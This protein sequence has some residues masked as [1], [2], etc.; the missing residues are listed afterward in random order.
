MAPG[1]GSV[2]LRL[3][4]GIG[5]PGSRATAG[6][7]SGGCQGGAGEGKKGTQHGKGAEVGTGPGAD[8]PAESPSSAQLRC[9]IWK[10]GPA[11]GLFGPACREQLARPRGRGPHFLR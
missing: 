4:G 3:A 8:P 2:T 10:P 9:Q 1:W 5:K 7:D 11:A 6:Q